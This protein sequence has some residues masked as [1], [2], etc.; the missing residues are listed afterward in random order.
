MVKEVE[1]TYKVEGLDLYTKS[2]L[3]DSDPVAKL[4]IVHG[5]SDHSGNYHEMAV[6]L[7]E[8]GI[9]VHSFD[10]RGWGR[11]VKRSADRG[12]CGGTDK[13]MG[14]IAGFIRSHLPAAPNCPVFVMGHSMGGGNVAWLCTDPA[15]EEDVLKQVRGF[16]LNAPFI[17][18]PPETR[19]GTVKVVLGRLAARLLPHQHLKHIIP[20]EMMTHDAQRVQQFRDDKLCHDTGTL[21]S[22][23]AL[24]DRHLILAPGKVLVRPGVRSLWLGHGTEDVGADYGAAKR[25]FEMQT[26]VQDKTFKT[27]EGW[28]HV[29]HCEVGK[30]EFF[31]DVR[32]W[33]LARCGDGAAA[34]AQ[35]EAVRKEEEGKPVEVVE[36]AEAK[37]VLA[38]E[39]KE[40]ADAVKDAEVVGKA[41]SAASGSKL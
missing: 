23:A 12:L 30:E 17:D 26:A 32:D 20:L 29:L 39:A 5:F 21:E 18:F 36:S 22:M 31:A 16:M 27:Y 24:L 2:W 13:V 33:I 3:P 28:Y 7:A 9:A 40:E 41:D 38:E 34:A 10:Q 6:W 25:W 19:P 14:E 35:S 1:G 11:N 8:R 4:L 15:L 37:K